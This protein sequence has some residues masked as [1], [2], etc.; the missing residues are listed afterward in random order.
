MAVSKNYRA[1][2]EFRKCIEKGK[3]VIYFGKDY[4]VL[5][6]EEYKKLKNGVTGGTPK[7]EP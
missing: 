1:Y 5:P 6:M 2:I 7:N 3:S 4:V